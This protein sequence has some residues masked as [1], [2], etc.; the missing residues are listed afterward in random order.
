MKKLILLTIICITPLITTAQ[1]QSKRATFKVTKP[2]NEDMI[3]AEDEEIP[4]EEATVFF[5]VEDMP[6]F[7]GGQTKLKEYISKNLKYPN[8]AIDKGIEGKV[9]VQ[10]VVNAQ[11]KVQDAKVVRGVDESLDSAALA[12]INSMPQWKPGKQRGKP[13]TVSYT[14]PVEFKLN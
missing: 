10:F 8:E 11:G 9:Y 6:E 7:P 1:T 4:D 5:I 3:T 2:I 13:V 14:V 12:V